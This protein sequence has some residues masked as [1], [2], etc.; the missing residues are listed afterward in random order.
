MELVAKLTR[1][2]TV[3]AAGSYNKS[4]LVKEVNF[5]DLQ[6]QPIDWPSLT[7]RRGN[8][9]RNP[10]GVAGDPLA[11]SPKLQ[12]S[13]RVRYDFMVNDY[14][15]F[16]QLAGQYHGSSYSTTDR[17]SHDLNNNSIAYLQPSYSQFDASTGVAKDAWSAQ[18]YASNLTDKRSIVSSN[19]SQWIK[20]DTVTRPRTIGLRIGYKF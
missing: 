14:E 5:V 3:S 1:S 16:W 4:E 12:G 11:Q 18:I 2:L 8:P 10:F 20:M 15:A 19:Y 7:D 13:L 17:L 9:L 6:G